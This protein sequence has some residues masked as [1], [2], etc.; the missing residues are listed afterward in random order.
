MPPFTLSQAQALVPLLQREMGCLLPSYHSLRVIWEETAN[1]IR[2]EVDDPE[3]R[4]HCLSDMRAV[5]AL[6]QIEA[7][8][9]LFQGLGIECRGIEEGS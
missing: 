7:S 5:R 6:R 9:S 8:L 3:V 4:Q 2:R 1:K